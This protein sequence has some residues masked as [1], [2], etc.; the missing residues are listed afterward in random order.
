MGRT[1]R[2]EKA[3]AEIVDEEVVEEAEADEELE[4]EV[5][6]TDSTGEVTE[7]GVYKG[8]TCVATFTLENHGKDFVKL[9]KAKAKT[10]GA[11]ARPYEDPVEAGK[12]KTV[13]NVVN[14]SNNLVRQFALSTHGKDY[15]KLANAFIEKHGEKKGYKIQ[16]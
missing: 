14:A 11:E 10:I 5:E 15:V 9:A 1:K 8:E 7:Y 6:T 2:E 12:E 16:K 4:A 3:E 13:V